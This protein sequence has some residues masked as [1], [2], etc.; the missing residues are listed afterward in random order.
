M[1]NP[2][3][4]EY[5]KRGRILTLSLKWS[6]D[7]FQMRA[8]DMGKEPLTEDELDICMISCKRGHDCT[9]GVTWDTLDIIT[10]MVQAG[11]YNEDIKQLQEN[12]KSESNM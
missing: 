5:D 12:R 8:L 9:L 3:G 2:Y 1:N 10:D 7:D 6:R 11:D 4:F